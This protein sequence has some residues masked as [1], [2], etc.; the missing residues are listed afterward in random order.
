[1]ASNDF[2]DI[3]IGL[4]ANP[5]EIVK[6][7]TKYSKPGTRSVSCKVAMFDSTTAAA[8]SVFESQWYDKCGKD[9]FI[10][11]SVLQEKTIES[12]DGREYFVLRC[13]MTTDEENFAASDDYKGDAPLHLG[14]LKPGHQLVAKARMVPWTYKNKCGISIYLNYVMA[15]AESGFEPLSDKSLL[16]GP[17]AMSWA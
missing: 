15:V 10:L 14:Q 7:T 11:D 8:I 4:M 12:P 17:K 1:M 13:K 9:K 5:V 16:A 3:Q 6:Y 2:M